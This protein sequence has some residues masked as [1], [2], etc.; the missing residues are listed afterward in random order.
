MRKL[1]L[2]F[3]LTISCLIAKSQSIT[4]IQPNGGEVLYSCQTYTV[5]WSQTGSPS[6]YWNVDYSLDG[7]II[8]TSVA[9]NY[10]STNGQF[11]WT[12][13]NVQSNTVLVRVYDAMNNTITDQSNAV[14]TINIPVLLTSPNGGEVWQGNT[15]QN[16]TW[17]AQGTSNTYNIAYST[18]GGSSWTN[19]VTNYYNTSGV[20]SWTVPNIPS[21]NCLVRVMDYVQNCMQDVSNGT[22]TI[23]PA[24]PILTAPN[25]GETLQQ[26]CTYYIT[27][28]SA[29][30]FTTVKLE[31]STNNGTS[32]NTITTA[33]T[34]N[35]SYGWTV[36]NI[37]SGQCLVRASNS[38]SLSVNDVSNATFTIAPAITVLSPNGGET[39]VGC[40]TYPITFAHTNCNSYYNIDYSTN[41]GSTW[42][43]IATSLYTSSTYT[44]S[45]NW[46]VP[47]GLTSSQCLIRVSDYYGTLASD[48]SN[49]NFNIIPSND[50][51]VTAPNGGENITG[52]STYTI[53]WTNLPSASGQYQLQYSTN[54]GSSWT[55]IVSNITGNA[56][57]WTVPNIPSTQ[58]LVKVI[59]YVTPC[60]YDNSDATFTISPATPTLTAPNGGETLQ[61]ECT[62]YITWNSAS[63]FTTVRLEYSTNNG[64]TW[65]TI[66]TAATNNGSYGWTVPNIGSGQCLVRA[67]NSTSLSVNDVSNATF[68]IAPAIT[69]LSPNGGE[70]WVGCSTYPITFAHTNCNSYYNIDYSTNGGSTWTNIAT[71]LYTSSTYT[72]SY[73]WQVPNGLTSSQCLI[74]VS[75]YYGTLASD[76]SNANFNIIP[77]NDITVTAP[78]GGENITGLSTYTI[79]WT[80]LPSASGQ[81]LSL[82]HI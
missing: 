52:L 68:T 1:L 12:V 6:N 60:K 39:W 29:S 69:V 33:A 22:F 47:N 55:N 43:N 17:N 2:L 38:T 66:T 78:N 62:Y 57:I 49:A 5:K 82:I 31:Y 44:T 20:Y 28:N 48:V 40:S 34:N 18:N 75:D 53:T 16:I 11:V 19:I 13:P 72:T 58:C 81:Y 32:W 9:S 24:T 30:F 36:P 73:N 77:S 71:S 80:N 14:F 27:W 46:Q 23:S 41:G 56:Y 21:T 45:Y 35:G 64:T 50:I 26:E 79:T 63:F 59:D 61:Q 54:N 76:V 51:T 10:L 67:S 3:A 15:V 70:T 65:N 8:W 74:R 42:T 37:G 4:I 7:G 25:G